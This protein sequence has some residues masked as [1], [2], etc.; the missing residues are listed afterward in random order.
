MQAMILT[1]FQHPFISISHSRAGQAS[2]SS[3]NAGGDDRPG[4]QF[5]SE[6]KEL[7]LARAWVTY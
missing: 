2:I 7:T 5:G 1:S 6:T 4:H 3:A